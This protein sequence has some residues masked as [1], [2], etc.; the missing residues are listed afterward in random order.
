MNSMQTQIN[1]E[2]KKR[3]ED[4]ECIEKNIDT[5]EKRLQELLIKKQ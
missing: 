3:A 4:T 5:I 1:I 2:G